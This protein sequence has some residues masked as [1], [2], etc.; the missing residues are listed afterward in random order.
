MQRVQSCEWKKKTQDHSAVAVP[1]STVDFS[2]PQK[3]TPQSSPVGAR[4]G[5]SFRVGNL[6]TV[7]PSNCSLI[8]MACC[9]RELCASF[10]QRWRYQ[11]EA[12]PHHWPFVNPKKPVS[13][14]CGVFFDLRLDKR[15]SKQLRGRWHE[16]YRPLWRHFNTKCIVSANVF[17]GPISLT[18][19]P[20]QFKF[21]P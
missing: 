4:C 21:S 1:L 10:F 7:Q 11:M 8:S 12:F 20:S 3:Q 5:M 13:R 17:L 16:S 15:L 6:F 2:D 9:N 14:S 19:F 18:V